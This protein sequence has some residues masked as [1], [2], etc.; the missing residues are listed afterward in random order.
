MGVYGRGGGRWGAESRVQKL[1]APGIQWGM[2]I[3]ERM[4]GWLQIR[5]PGRLWLLFPP[6]RSTLPSAWRVVLHP[7]SRFQR[8][9]RGRISRPSQMD[10][11]LHWAWA[12][13]RAAGCIKE[14]MMPV[15]CQDLRAN[16]TGLGPCENLGWPLLCLGLGPTWQT[17]QKLSCLD[18]VSK[19]FGSSQRFGDWIRN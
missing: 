19:P 12:L 15:A 5:G 3:A 1:L 6:S 18:G 16:Q 4:Q 2:G 13:D 17:K 9:Q 11:V 8:Q 14:V 10:C 7:K